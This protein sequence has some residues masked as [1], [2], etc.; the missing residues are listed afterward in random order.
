MP[1]SKVVPL[2]NPIYDASGN[3]I[4]AAY[5][6]ISVLNANPISQTFQLCYSGF[7]SAQSYQAD[8]VQN[9]LM[10]QVIAYPDP[11]NAPGATWPFAPATLAANFPNNPLAILM[12]ADA[13][14]MLNP[15]FAGGSEVS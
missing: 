14:A 1:I 15:F 13:Y 9:P 2:V 4:N 8:P 11:V 3:L 7:S 5:W 10:T 12:A 6:R